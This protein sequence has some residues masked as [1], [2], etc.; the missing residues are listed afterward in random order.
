MPL[1]TVETTYRL[2]VYRQRSYRA[3]SP[4]E[5]CRL[6][7]DDDGWEDAKEDVETSG[8][9][10]VTGLWKGRDAA[11]S[12]PEIAIPDEF[13]ETVQR[14]AEL[15]DILV[16]IVRE[17]V[18]PMGLSQYEFERWLPR[19]LAVLARAEAISRVPMSTPA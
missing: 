7:V 4:E 15:F 19:A 10:H 9:T 12:G 16:A 18:R 17:P 13:D 11:C 1:Y 6:A 8:E 14:K 3:A 5:A 2:P